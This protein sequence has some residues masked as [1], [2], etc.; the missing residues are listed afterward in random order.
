[1]DAKDLSQKSMREYIREMF[2]MVYNI[3]NPWT[4][5]GTMESPVRGWEVQY[6]TYEMYAWVTARTGG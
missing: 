1:M 4:S 6:G 2:E 5:P 3:K